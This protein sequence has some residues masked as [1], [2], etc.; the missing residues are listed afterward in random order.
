MTFWGEVWR[1]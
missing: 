1:D